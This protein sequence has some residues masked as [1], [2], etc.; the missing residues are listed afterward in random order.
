MFTPENY[1]IYG[2]G[3]IILVVWIVLYLLGYKHADL[4]NYLEEKEYPLKEIYFVGF[5]LMTII[6]YPY[7]SK[8][9]RKLRKEISILYDEKYA[10][11]YLRVIYSQKITMALTIAILSFVLYGLANDTGVLVVMLVFSGLAYYY[12]GIATEKKIFKRSEE[13][14]RDFSD[15]TSKLA[16]LTNAGMILREAWAEVAYTGTTTLYVE[17]QKAVDDMKNGVS[18]VDALKEFGVKCV[19]PE[20]KKLTSTIVQGLVKGNKEL[21]KMLTEQSREVWSAKKHDIRR[22]GEKA[23]S[24]LLIPISI[25]FIGILIMIIVPIFASIG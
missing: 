16:L 24:K 4:F 3:S 17:M 8:H 1:I 7:K 9:D 10:D 13:M 22:K 23:A 18:E 20:I 2:A 25:M 5:T 6:K 19:V 21:T 11:Y 15:V 12:F 14:L